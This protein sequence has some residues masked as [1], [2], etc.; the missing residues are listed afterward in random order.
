MPEFTSNKPN[1][2]P[3]EQMSES[4]LLAAEKAA[5]K[6]NIN[7]TLER[8]RDDLAASADVAAWT[9]KYPWASVGAAAGIGFLAA[10]LI[11][12]RKSRDHVAEALSQALNAKQEPEP[13]PGIVSSL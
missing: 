2:L 6:E 11:S 10:T 3:S 8:M 4:E 12:S 9:R 13:K 5:A 1:R 7:A